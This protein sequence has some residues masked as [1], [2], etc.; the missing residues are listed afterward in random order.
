M[1]KTAIIFIDTHGGYENMNDWE[2]TKK[3]VKEHD[4]NFV[5]PS[6]LSNLN[7]IKINKIS[8]G[9]CSF[10]RPEQLQKL[11][12]NIRLNK[13]SPLEKQK[14]LE[15]L[16][17]YL[18]RKLKEVDEEYQ[19]LKRCKKDNKDIEVLIDNNYRE[20]EK[21]NDYKLNKFN[22]N[23][24]TSNR[25]RHRINKIDSRENNDK[26][27]NKIYQYGI[28]KRDQH[29]ENDNYYAESITALIRPNNSTKFKE[30]TDF[31]KGIEHKWDDNDTIE[32]SL[33]EL[34][35]H[36]KKMKVKNIL[37]I[38][39]TCNTIEP[40]LLESFGITEEF[41]TEQKTKKNNTVKSCKC[42]EFSF[43]GGNKKTLKRINKSK[44][45]KSRRKTKM[46]HN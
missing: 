46:K 24:R 9:L 44:Y 42:K 15:D 36:L 11:F 38:D 28:E 40:S 41:I 45:S 12:T 34:L 16:A 23:I 14:T 30:I 18:Q 25:K 13:G 20:N 3:T 10:S 32:F 29:R 4:N 8:P 37:I 33:E 35:K 31:T 19:D 6:V 5:R 39:L 1:N 17:K 2:F 7:I 22:I 26:I 43:F 27:L 21:W